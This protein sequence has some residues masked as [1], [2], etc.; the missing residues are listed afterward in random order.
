MRKAITPQAIAKLTIDVLKLISAAIAKIQ[1]EKIHSMPS[2][3]VL[4]IVN[5]VTIFSTCD[6]GNFDA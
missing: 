3:A 4:E 1:I 2:R 6:N 5:G